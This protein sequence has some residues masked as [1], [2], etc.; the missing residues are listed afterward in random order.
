MTSNSTKPQLAIVV[1]AEEEFDWSKDFDRDNISVGHMEQIHRAQSIFDE[2][3][4][5]P[6]YVVG[7]PIAAQ[8]LGF[9]LL[10]EYLDSGRALIGAH[11]HPWVTPPLDELVTPSNSYPGNLPRELAAQKLSM[12]TDKIEES[13]G[14]RPTIYKAGRYGLGPNTYTILE[15]QGYEIDLSPCPPMD[16]S[17]DGGPDFT[18]HKSEPLFFGT[19]NQLM[20]LPNTGAFIGSLSAIG[21]SL[22]AVIERPDL[23]WA[24]LPGIAARLGL[25]ERL[26]LSPETSGLADMIRLTK[27]L[28]ARGTRAFSFSFHSPNI[29]PGHTPYVQSE[30]E[31]EQFLGAIK[32]YLDYFV[33]DLGGVF[34][35]P[36]EIKANLDSH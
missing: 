9:T 3:D 5:V 10:K 28:Y 14:G 25:F 16:L 18:R 2:F 34:A 19:R 33:S 31:L 23:Q 22:F 6:V 26:R 11:L 30:D 20:Y 7:Y 1:D 32:N 24:R 13:F 36:H 4:A 29:E 12:L 35:T 17:E 8:P 27:W 21:P 15:E